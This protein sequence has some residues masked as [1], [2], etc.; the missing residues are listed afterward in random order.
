MGDGEESM[1]ELD[2]LD[3]EEDC[4]RRGGEPAEEKDEVRV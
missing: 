1:L 4:R 2:A 3:E